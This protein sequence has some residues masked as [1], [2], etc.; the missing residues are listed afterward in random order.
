MRKAILGTQKRG[1]LLGRIQGDAVAALVP[2]GDR[3]VKLR[4]VRDGIDVVAAVRDT[5]R[6]GIYDV[7]RRGNVRCADA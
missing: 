6:D 3:F 7:S 1:D 4:A 2:A 5:F